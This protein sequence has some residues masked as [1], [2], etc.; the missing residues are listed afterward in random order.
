MSKSKVAVEHMELRAK[1]VLFSKPDTTMTI[2]RMVCNSN[3]LSVFDEAYIT[4]QDLLLTTE[5]SGRGLVVELSSSAQIE[6]TSNLTMETVNASIAVRLSKSARLVATGSAVMHMTELSLVSASTFLA[7]QSSVSVSI[8][9]VN[10]SN[11]VGDVM[12]VNGTDLNGCN[13]KLAD[14]AE[15]KLASLMISSTPL[16]DHCAFVMQR[17]AL[18]KSSSLA[19]DGKSPRAASH[20]PPAYPAL[21]PALVL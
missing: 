17:G 5:E 21:M 20:K 4:V 3:Y 10:S 2:H 1:N 12:V 6:V 9:L 14:F 18:Y 16:L 19:F 8:L 15:V 7:N 13:A 11:L